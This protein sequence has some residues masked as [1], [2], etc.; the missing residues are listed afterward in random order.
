MLISLSDTR[1][2]W[3]R[4][5]CD[6]SVGGSAEGSSAG[7]CIR[8]KFGAEAEGWL[9][10]L[11]GPGGSGLSRF[12]GPETTLI[13]AELDLTGEGRALI[14]ESGIFNFWADRFGIARGFGFSVVVFR[15]NFGDG[16]G[17]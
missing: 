3:M 15:G 6:S 1:L 14:G 17:V 11:P 10:L 4:R 7:P 9:A 16:S 13:N 2:V 5:C 12:G 8:D